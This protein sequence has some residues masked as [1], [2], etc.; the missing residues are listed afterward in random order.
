V[1]SGDVLRCLRAVGVDFVQGF[2]VERP[3]YVEQ[4][5]EELL[6]EMPPS[7]AAASEAS[8]SG[9]GGRAEVAEHTLKF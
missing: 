9:A 6:K 7:V 4:L 8:A 1:E 2:H 3:M 5:T